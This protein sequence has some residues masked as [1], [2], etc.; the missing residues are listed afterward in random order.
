MTNTM[1]D[2]TTSEDYPDPEPAPAEPLSVDAIKTGLRA[3]RAA[4]VNEIST[5]VE[6]RNAANAKIKLLRAD[7]ESAER[8]LRAMEPRKRK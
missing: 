6:T 8:V 2:T 3:Q 4:I 5:L 1:T 7:L